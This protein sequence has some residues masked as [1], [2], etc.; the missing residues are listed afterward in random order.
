MRDLEP[1]MR[2]QVRV[3]DGDAAGHRDAVHGKA[4]GRSAMQESGLRMESML[5]L[6]AA[7]RRAF[8]P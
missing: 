3:T 8:N 5:R 2:Y 7:R 4:H 6:H 1:G